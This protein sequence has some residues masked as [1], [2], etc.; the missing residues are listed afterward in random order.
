M[1]SAI[2][3]GVA[4]RFGRV[5]ASIVCLDASGSSKW[6]SV[7]ADAD[8]HAVRGDVEPGTFE[9]SRLREAYEAGL[10][11]AVA[12]ISIPSDDRWPSR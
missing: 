8:E 6:L 10:R 11:G 5:L 9:G 2:S 12:R 7:A 4:A 1:A 3:L